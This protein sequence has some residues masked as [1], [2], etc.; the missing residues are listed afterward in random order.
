[1]IFNFQARRLYSRAEMPAVLASPRNS[2]HFNYR[3]WF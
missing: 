1:M 3:A 2:M